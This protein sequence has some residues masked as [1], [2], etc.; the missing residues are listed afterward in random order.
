MGDGNEF[1]WERSIGQL[2][3]LADLGQFALK[4]HVFSDG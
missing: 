2:A 1:V 3:L 4:K